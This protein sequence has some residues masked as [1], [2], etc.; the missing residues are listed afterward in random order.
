MKVIISLLAILLTNISYASQSIK[1]HEGGNN[2]Y[3]VELLS[4][5]GIG[6]KNG[7]EIIKNAVMKKCEEKP[8][9]LGKYRFSN[10][11]RVSISD[12]PSEDSFRM[13]QQLFCG[14]LPPSIAQ[15]NTKPLSDEEK[16]NLEEQARKSTDKYLGYLANFDFKNA[17]SLLTSSLKGDKT[18][19]EWTTTKKQLTSLPGKLLRSETWGV[20]TYVDPPSSSRK[21]V[22]I[23]TDFDREYANS[24]IFCGYLVW[25]LEGSELKVIREDIG[26]IKPGQISKMSTEDLVIAKSKFR[27]KPLTNKGS[28]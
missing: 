28:G 13:I 11:E 17:Y 24:P 12:E 18:Y 3:V 5:K 25:Y 10:E 2:S 4:S 20:T 16:Y 1:F 6:E 7:L 15:E 26:S 14:E 19:E 27:C 22:Y 8:V 21:G 9:H 23:A